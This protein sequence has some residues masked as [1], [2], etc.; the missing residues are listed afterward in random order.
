[1]DAQT[2]TLIAMIGAGEDDASDAELRQAWA[3]WASQDAEPGSVTDS[4]V[5][6]DVAPD[7]VPDVAS[8]F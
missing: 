3:A 7:A 4:V 1:M 5:E 2:R 6:P 8:S